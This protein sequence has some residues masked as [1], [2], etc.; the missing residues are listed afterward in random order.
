VK[1]P[2]LILTDMAQGRVWKAEEDLPLARYHNPDG[3]S[4]LAPDQEA[5]FEDMRSTLDAPKRRTPQ[6]RLEATMTP[7]VEGALRAY[8]KTGHIIWPRSAQLALEGIAT[9]NRDPDLL[10][11]GGVDQVIKQGVA[12]ARYIAE[13]GDQQQKAQDHKR[14]ARS[15]SGH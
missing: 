8:E 13:Q 7:L 1:K 6:E 5:V 14:T 12:L 9:L 4:F 15:W 3:S 10:K 11:D 2:R